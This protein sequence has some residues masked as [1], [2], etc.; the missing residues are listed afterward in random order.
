MVL[1]A[2]AGLMIFGLT[3][4]KGRLTRWSALLAAAVL[5]GGVVIFSPTFGLGNGVLVIGLGC[6]L[7]YVGGLLARR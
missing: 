1:L 2:L 5:V 3:G 4:T 7:G 6:V